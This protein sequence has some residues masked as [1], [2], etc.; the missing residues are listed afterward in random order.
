MNIYTEPSQLAPG[1]REA[2]RYEREKLAPDLMQ[3]IAVLGTLRFEKI[4]QNASRLVTFE[5]MTE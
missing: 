1:W 5:G 3:L 4:T 2:V